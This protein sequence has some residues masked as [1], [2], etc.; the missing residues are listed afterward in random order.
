VIVGENFLSCH[1]S[2]EP[3]TSSRRDDKT[4]EGNVHIA[5]SSTAKSVVV[6]VDDVDDR[7]L[8]SSCETPIFEI[9]ESPLASVPNRW[10]AAFMVPLDTFLLI[11]SCVLSLYAC[12]V[13]RRAEILAR[14]V[15]ELPQKLFQQVGALAAA[16]ESLD[17]RFSSKN[18]REAAAKSVETRAVAGGGNGGQIARGDYAALDNWMKE[19]G[20]M[21]G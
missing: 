6:K 3:V 14:T 12:R 13:A 21:G 11:V 5:L 8:W 1:Q 2:S 17:D 15:P 20:M 7:R 9:C 19:N 4:H 18:K 10:Y 16:L